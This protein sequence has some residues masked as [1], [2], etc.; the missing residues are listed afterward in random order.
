RVAINDHFFWTSIACIHQTV[1]DNV[2]VF[3]TRLSRGEDLE[4]WARIGRKYRFIKS[5]VVTAIYR[6][7]AENRSVRAFDLRK[8]RVFNYDF[9]S[10]TSLEET[11]Y[12]KVQIVNSL[13]RALAKKKVK[14]FFNLRCKHAKYISWVDVLKK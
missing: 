11:A 12:Y 6:T 9:S 1:F 5:N 7:D 8:S 14:N 4:L 13:R 10:S 2:G 3:D